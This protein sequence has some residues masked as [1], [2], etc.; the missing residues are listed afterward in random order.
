MTE[1]QIAQQAYDGAYDAAS[2]VTRHTQTVEEAALHAVRTIFNKLDQWDGRPIGNWAAIIGRNKAID[3]RKKFH[4]EKEY[5]SFEH[6]MT[7][8][9]PDEPRDY[10]KLHGALSKLSSKKQELMSMY[11][12]KEM[13]MQTIAEETGYSL[14][15]VKI[16][17]MRGRQQI[18]KLLE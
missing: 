1:N 12:F 18:K 5:D 13:E 2:R 15:D 8:I 4:R 7:A 11:Y 10:T 9:T 3:I 6:S 14:S 16:S 17:I